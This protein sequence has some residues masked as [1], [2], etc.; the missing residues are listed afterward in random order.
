MSDA[1]IFAQK[2]MSS[3]FALGLRGL[4]FAASLGLHGLA[5]A[6]F[7]PS[8]SEEEAPV[9]SLELSIAPPQ[10][11]TMIEEA[12]AVDS[13]AQA[14][15]VASIQKTETPPPVV[16]EAPEAA[17]VVDQDA[18]TIT[19]SIKQEEPPPPQMQE[20]VPE[21]P[22]MDAQSAP[23]AQQVN[24]AEETF[25]RRAVGVENGLH[26]GGGTTRAAYA[27]AVKKEIARNKRRPD[28][29]D[30]GTVSVSFVIGA[31]G[32]AEDITIVRPA[33]PKLDSTARGILASVTLPPPPGGK[34]QGMVAIKFE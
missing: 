13:A 33:A 28:G 27:A 21:T 8:T 15:T 5:F 9:D 1:G 31:T 4:F 23:N 19:A 24:A 26:T 25:A 12:D 16:E 34:F 17:K 29:A 14:E 30:H 7:L 11:E 3:T 18:E 22:H 32:G 20:P 10:G 2:P 6:A